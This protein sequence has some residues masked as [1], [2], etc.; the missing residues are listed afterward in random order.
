MERFLEIGGELELKWT[1]F[2]D[3]VENV[4]DDCY[5]QVSLKEYLV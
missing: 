1:E 4:I 2:T 5:E 3:D